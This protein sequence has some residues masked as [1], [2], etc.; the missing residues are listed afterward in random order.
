MS[1]RLAETR[2]ISE[3]EAIARAE[4]EKAY[5]EAAALETAR[6][7]AQQEAAR[8]VGEVAGA[9]RCMMGMASDVAWGTATA[10]AA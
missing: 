7:W 5:R 6:V 3:A 10:A 2:K 1:C 8:K 4:R 9:V